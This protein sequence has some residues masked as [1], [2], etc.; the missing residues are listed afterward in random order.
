IDFLYRHNI[1]LFI[2]IHHDSVSHNSDYYRQKINK[3]LIHCLNRYGKHY[4]Q[5]WRF[6]YYSADKFMA[7][8][9][10]LI[11]YYRLMRKHILQLLPATQV[12]V[13]HPLLGNKQQ[14]EQFWSSE[15][16]QEIDFLGYSAD[17]NHHINIDNLNNDHPK[18]ELAYIEQKTILIKQQ[19]KKLQLDLPLILLN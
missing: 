6:I 15:L 10:T 16:I 17:I 1:A 8:D 9:I 3:F 12:G 7:D 19:L 2:R 18:H 11:H 4:V 13:F 5:N 14:Q